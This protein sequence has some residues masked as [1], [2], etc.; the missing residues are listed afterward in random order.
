MSAASIVGLA[1]IGKAA[2]RR[3]E[4]DRSGAPG[5]ALRH[6]NQQMLIHELIRGSLGQFFLA[7]VDHFEK[8]VIDSQRAHFL[9]AYHVLGV[10]QVGITDR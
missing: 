6:F 3:F 1:K 9:Q 2:M 8:C 7:G 4:L 10:Y 5:P